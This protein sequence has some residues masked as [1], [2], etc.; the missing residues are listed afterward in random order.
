MI[1]VPDR[2]RLWL[3]PPGILLL[4]AVASGPFL[5]GC[6]NTSAVVSPTATPTVTLI[7]VTGTAALTDKGQTSQLTATATL[8]DGTAQNVTNSALWQSSIPATAAVSNT[9][10]VTALAIGTPTITATHQGKSG[11]LAL[12][13]GAPASQPQSLAELIQ[14]F[15]YQSQTG[16]ITVGS[17]MSS[18]FSQQH[19][20]HASLVWNYFSAFFG[21][22]PGNHTELYYTNT[23]A[24][25]A[26]L[27]AFCPTEVIAGAR[28]LTACFDSAQRFWRWF[29][30]PDMTPDFGTQRHELSHIFLQTVY[31]TGEDYVWFKEGTGMYWESGAM[32]GTALV[33]ERPLPY[34]TQGFRSAHDSGR[35]VPLNV[36]LRYRRAEFY[37]APDATVVY[38]EAGMLVFYLMKTH[39]SVMADLFAGLRAGSGV[40]SNDQLLAFLSSR[41]GQTLEQLDAAYTAFSLSY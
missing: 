29:I 8:S 5:G 12:S 26:Q 24:L 25:Y 13:I 11:T 34:L 33:V 7:V 27:F 17:T 28:Q 20:D 2:R 16:L 14:R 37:G 40:A 30:M 22:T 18:A 38:S 4:A 35:Q 32:E 10:L 9:G 31:P 3:H 36:L 1:V 15:N 39:P 41:T 23:F 21:R 19:S 6:G